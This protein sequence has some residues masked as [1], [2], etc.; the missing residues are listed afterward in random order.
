M[1][2][3]YLIFLGALCSLPMKANSL[4][5][6]E[7]HPMALKGEA[8]TSHTKKANIQKV[9]EE[10]RSIVMN[11]PAVAAEESTGL[12]IEGE[13]NF[14]MEGLMWDDL[15]DTDWYGML[16]GKTFLLESTART[17]YPIIGEFDATTNQLT[18]SKRYVGRDWRGRYFF[19]EPYTVQNSKLVSAP[20]TAQFYPNTGELKFKPGDYLVWID[21]EDLEGTK[22]SYDEGDWYI[23]E[24]AK[25][26]GDLDKE[27]PD[28]WEYQGEATLIDGWV[29][30][31]FGLEQNLQDNWLKAGLYKYKKN[32]NLYRL[33]NPFE[34]LKIDGYEMLLKTGYI[35]FDISDPEHV[36]FNRVDAGWTCPKIGINKFYCYNILGYYME[37]F[38][39]AGDNQSVQDFV[40]FTNP[41]IPYTTYKDGI[42]DLT[43]FLYGGEITYDAN[44]GDS[45]YPTGG[46]MWIGM[47]MRSRIYFPDVK[48]TEPQIE[49]VGEPSAAFDS[50]SKSAEIELNFTYQ[51][52]PENGTVFVVVYDKVSGL[53]VARKYVNESKYSD[54]HYSFVLEGL[55]ADGKDNY[56][57]R[58]QMEGGLS[59]I[60]AKSQPKDLD[61]TVDSK[62]QRA[63][64]VD[65]VDS[66][67]DTPI[68][69]NLQGVRVDNP[70]KGEIYI[71]VKG[72]KAV[73]VIF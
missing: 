73:K 25:R 17:G 43:G 28:F 68:Y 71:K 46:N 42:V 37:E 6:V 27:N 24:S 58:V 57:M 41:F 13:W 9:T 35:E 59:Q 62:E 60:L 7:R 30:P 50:E 1:K 29:S 45:N 49:F 11:S 51:N 18:I 31:R 70:A 23:V 12:S 63:A 53:L 15:T 5:F 69:Y 56:A 72:G 39:M 48:V 52:K 33:K 20:I 66:D 38:R 34:G 54:N 21:Y 19:I 65:G 36:L 16:V 61:F 32:S 26:T 14:K 67:T 55:D 22:N 44:F 47:N 10:A 8:E 40:Q 4:E 2:L 3:A 64:G